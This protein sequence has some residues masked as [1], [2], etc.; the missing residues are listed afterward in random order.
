MVVVGI[1]IWIVQVT[2][3]G[4]GGEVQFE[5]GSGQLTV[6]TGGAIGGFSIRIKSTISS[7]SSLY[8]VNIRVVVL[9]Y[10]VVQFIH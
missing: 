9:Q 3:G 5:I 1:H 8:Q 6:T 7:V 2:H 4:T 10:E